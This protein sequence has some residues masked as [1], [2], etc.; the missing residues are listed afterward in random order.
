[1]F[2]DVMINEY[3]FRELVNKPSSEE[4]QAYYSKS[5]YQRSM[6]SSY[7]SSYSSL[8]IEHRTNLIQQKYAVLKHL[9]PNSGAKCR[10]LDVGCGEGWALKYFKEKLWDVVGLDY[11]DYGINTHNQSCLDQ[12]I[13][14]DISKSIASLINGNQQF[15][16]ILLDNVLEHVL[17]PIEILRQLSRLISPNGVMVIQVPNDFSLV[18]QYLYESGNVEHPYWIAKPDHISYFNVEGLKSI[19]RKAGWSCHEIMG[20]FP[21][22]FNLFNERTNYVKDKHLGKGC[23]NSRMV[24]ENFLNSTFGERIN[25]LYRELG[26]L[27]LGRQITGFFKLG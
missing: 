23:H 21:V 24:L 9:I 6:S 11:S 14:G 17:E 25:G 3:G 1:M 13:I 2:K 5:Y 8:E 7:E 19:C 12:L 16:V 18:Q 27:G 22:D 10:L 15:D 26:E 4:L 20:T